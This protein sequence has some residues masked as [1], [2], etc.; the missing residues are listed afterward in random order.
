[1]IKKFLEYNDPGY[2]EIT[3]LEYRSTYI[4]KEIDNNIEEELDLINNILPYD[5]FASICEYPG[6]QRCIN[7]YPVS[8]I[9]QVSSHRLANIDK[10]VDEWYLV[11]ISNTLYRCDQ[12]Y[13]LTNCINNCLP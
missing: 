4:K 12:M 11:E 2:I 1:M 8:D 9:P 5:R 3:L 10:L 7:I 13:G 6:G